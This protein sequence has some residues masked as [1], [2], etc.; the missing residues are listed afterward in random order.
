MKLPLVGTESDEHIGF[1]SVDPKTGEILS[2]DGIKADSLIGV[3]PYGLVSI[4]T[5]DEHGEEC[6]D[7]STAPSSP[8]DPCYHGN[9]NDCLRR[10]NLRAVR[11][12]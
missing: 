6:Y 1:V 2:F 12:R 4:Q 3:Q 5:T 7:S 10:E 9:L 11:Q 8:D